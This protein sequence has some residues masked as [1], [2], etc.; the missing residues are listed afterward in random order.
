MPRVLKKIADLT[1]AKCLGIYRARKAAGC[2]K[3]PSNFGALRVAKCAL[4][5][6]L[7]LAAKVALPVAICKRSEFPRYFLICLSECMRKRISIFD[8][9]VLTHDALLLATLFA[10]QIR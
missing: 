6:S 10:Q 7:G 8:I 5:M 9:Q 3:F 1:L 4:I 2:A